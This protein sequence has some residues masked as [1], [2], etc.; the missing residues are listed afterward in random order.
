MCSSD[1]S[2]AALIPL[3]GHDASLFVDLVVEF[4]QRVEL[5]DFGALSLHVLVGKCL[6]L[7]H[8]E[9]CDWFFSKE[10]TVGVRDD[11]VLDVH[12]DFAVSDCAIFLIDNDLGR[13]VVRELEG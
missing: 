2:P 12:V 13:A 8:V 3:D 4:G 9:D 7:E 10:V 1:L 5:I 11:Q 6:D